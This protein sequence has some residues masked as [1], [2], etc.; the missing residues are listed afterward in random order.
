MHPVTKEH[1]NLVI[2]SEAQEDPAGRGYAGKSASEIF[3]LMRSPYEP[4][5]PVV[6]QDVL[7]SDVRGYL[8]ARLVLVRLEDWAPTAEAGNARDAARTLL[9]VTSAPGLT[10]FTTSRPTGRENVLGLFGLLVQAGAGGLTQQH[11]D[12]IAAM[13]V[14]PSPAAAEAPARWQIVISGISGHD[15]QA[16]PPNVAELALIEDALAP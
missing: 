9:R 15:G 4:S 3:D 2:R 14:A 7:I 6:Y 8:E 10:Y 1:L 12:E 11:Y 13:T 5:M 16:G